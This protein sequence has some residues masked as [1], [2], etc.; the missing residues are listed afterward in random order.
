MFTLLG[1][2]GGDQVS[3]AHK[4]CGQALNHLNGANGSVPV[5]S[6]Y[7]QKEHNGKF[8]GNIER[9]AYT[10]QTDLIMRQLPLF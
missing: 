2:T 1:P 9:D 6:E 5:I 8:T 7:M 4:F 3:C 10:R